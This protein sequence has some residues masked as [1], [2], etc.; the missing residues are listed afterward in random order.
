MLKMFFMSFNYITCSLAQMYVKTYFVLKLSHH[1][2]QNEER[3]TSPVL[4]TAFTTYNKT[5][6]LM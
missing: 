5:D 6:G 1:T 4:L 2:Q 3:N